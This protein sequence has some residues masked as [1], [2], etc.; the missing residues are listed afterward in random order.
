MEATRHDALD[1]TVPCE[2]FGFDY[3]TDI[4]VGEFDGRAG[5]ELFSTSGG[6][7]HSLDGGEVQQF[8]GR[9]TLASL[10]QAVAVDLDGDGVHEILAH[11]FTNNSASG[12]GYVI[13]YQSRDGGAPTSSSDIY[14]GF[15]FAADARLLAA[16]ID[17]DAHDDFWI[18]GGFG[19][20]Y[21]YTIDPSG[22]RLLLATVPF[23]NNW[24]LPTTH[25]GAWHSVDLNGDG[26]SDLVLAGSG[27]TL[28]VFMTRLGD[29]GIETST[30][31]HPSRSGKTI[32]IADLNLDGR[33]DLA[34]WLQASLW[35]QPADLAIYSGLS[36]GGFVA[37]PLLP[38]TS[39]SIGI[40]AVGDLNID[41]LPDL[42]AFGMSSGGLTTYLGQAD[43]G[44]NGP[45]AAP[46]SG[47]ISRV[48][49]A[50][51]MRD[52]RPEVIVNGA[53]FSGTC[54]R[55][56]SAVDAGAGTGGGGGS[57]GTGGGSTG[58]GGGSS[59][60]GGG[61]TGT[62]GGAP[63]GD[64]GSTFTGGGSGGGDDLADGGGGSE[65]TRMGPTGCG[66]RAG[67]LR[68]SMARAGDPRRRS[69]PAIDATIACLRGY[70]TDVSDFDLKA[71]RS[72]LVYRPISRWRT[73]TALPPAPIPTG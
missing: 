59:G 49:V 33:L 31:T 39:T 61:S 19:P 35:G 62:G 36:D 18:A 52:A 2:R 70:L 41:G 51:V 66:R 55:T 27:R 40:L 58:T 11:E 3:S 38:L 32:A 1:E 25:G 17:A 14:S 50:D 23:P 60:T 37:Q 13:R 47:T 16:R 63:G 4:A 20:A 29:G 43:G 67:G 46:S 72:P 42:V 69:T 12:N 68:N 21:G 45:F 44:W 26:S 24:E 5:L 28:A 64:G 8:G 56:N 53:I 34:V 71:G 65:V 30:L 73:S 9:G 57:T 54:Y 48:F 6:F 15:A 7:W 10:D 22:T